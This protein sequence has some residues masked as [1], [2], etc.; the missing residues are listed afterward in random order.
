[1]F[2]RDSQAAAGDRFSLDWVPDIQG[3]GRFDLPGLPG[4][5]LYLA[6]TPEHAVAENIQHFRG[7]RMNPADLTVA[8][9]PLALVPVDLSVRAADHIVDLCDAAELVAHGLRPDQT[10]SGQRHITQ[11]IAARLYGGGYP[12]LRWWSALSGD[13][14]TVVLFRNR[15]RG[16]LTFGN[17]APLS[18][19]DEAVKEAVR[20][21]GMAVDT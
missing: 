1:M 9:H 5:V 7:Q 16:Q 21:L 20:V 10:A 8:G 2:P 6:E 17:P 19:T 4:G 3:N 15:I 11:G 18:L 12:G 13:W 14:H